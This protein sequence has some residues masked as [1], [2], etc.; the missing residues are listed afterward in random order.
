MTA[1]FREMQREG[2]SCVSLQNLVSSGDFDNVVKEAAAAVGLQ[3]F[4]VSQSRSAVASWP[5]GWDDYLRTRDGKFLRNLRSRRRKL[6]QAGFS[7]HLLRTPEEFAE[8]WPTVLDIETSCWK[9]ARQSSM[10][11]EKGTAAFYEEVG[12][13]LARTNALRLYL[14]K[15]EDT[16]VA[17]AFGAAQ[18]QA[19]FLLKNSY[20][21]AYKSWS[22]GVSLVW[23]SM[24]DAAE[25][26]C[27]VYDF[28]G[29]ATDWK[30]DFCTSEP[31]YLSRRL[32][33]TAALR[34]QLCRLREETLK[35]LARRLR[36]KQVLARFGALPR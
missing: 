24:Q 1:I 11:N 33:A 3:S 7:V 29:D 30:R 27:A 22:P 25:A 9:H 2:H 6:D 35:P 14:L 21:D 10:A 26:G 5:G 4:D 23:Q 20:D 16:A 34:C 13:R 28:L 32:F 18:N 36:L 15:H 19:F 12:Q 17:H 8:A 31:A